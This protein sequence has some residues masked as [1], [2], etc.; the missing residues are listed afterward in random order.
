MFYIL[1]FLGFSQIKTIHEVT[2]IPPLLEMVRRA[3]QNRES[4]AVREVVREAVQGVVREAVL[5]GSAEIRTVAS[6]N[7]D[8]CAHAISTTD[9]FTE[10]GYDATKFSQNLPIS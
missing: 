8:R 3:V 1:P 4:G 5:T 7:V 9:I 10:N 2:Q 6:H